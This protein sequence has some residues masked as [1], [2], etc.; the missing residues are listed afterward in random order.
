MAL[1]LGGLGSQALAQSVDAPGPSEGAAR[2]QGL[3]VR[4]RLSFTE[5]VTDNLLSSAGGSA[6]ASGPKD[7]AL[8]TTLSPGLSV[9]S[10]TGRLR[11][12]L[13]YALNGIAYLKSERPSRVQNSLTAQ[14]TL[15]VV[16]RAVSVD[17]RAT[18]GQQTASAFG[19]QTADPSLS[20]PNQHEVMTATVMPAWRGVV[21]GLLAFDLSAS[22]SRTEVRGTSLG[23]GHTEMGSLRLSSAHAGAVSVWSLLSDQRTDYAGN[24]AGNR[25]SALTAGADY[26]PD[27]D[28]RVGFSGGAER[29]NY[30]TATSANGKTYGVNV[31]WTPSPR[32]RLNGDWHH[33]SYGNSQSLVFSHRL[34]R[35]AFQFSDTRSLNLGNTA[36][37]ATRTNYDLYF[38]QFASLQPDPVKRDVLVREFL[39]AQ[40]LS[41]DAP[42]TTGFLSAGPSRLHSQ[43]LSASYQGL[44]TSFTVAYTHGQTRTV[45]TTAAVGDLAVSGNVDQRTYSLNVGHRLTPESSL[46]LAVSRQESRGSTVAQSTSLS[47]VTANWSAR[48]GQRLSV[49]LGG[50]HSRF[51]GLQPY[52]ENSLTANLTQQF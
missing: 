14:G 2:P 35:A 41:P 45:G 37:G 48:L 31:D 7:A 21:G 18:I 19:L 12:S 42:V 43:L 27:P 13:D 24:A 40:G 6:V 16:D 28:W 52:S 25:L 23:D 38:L 50:R 10:N 36:A 32:T 5:T 46:S 33:H 3:S 22:E 9:V 1:V 47:S 26:R 8:I 34:A 17:M 20:N 15:E 39:L 4:P 29:S 51:T 30:V 44:R 49:Q 11:G